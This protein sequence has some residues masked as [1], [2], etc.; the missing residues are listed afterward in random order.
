MLVPAVAGAAEWYEKIKLG[1]D[2]RFRNEL[3]QQQDKKDDFR[4]RIR[5]R[6]AVEAQVTESWSAAIG[7]ASG[8][9][10]PVSTNQTLT[11]GFSRKTIMLDLAYIDF[12]PT[13]VPGLNMIGGKMR[14]PFETADRTQLV[15]DN[16]LAPEGIAL[17]YKHAAGE[18]V[19]LFMN[20]AGFYIT[21]NDPDNEQWMSGG[22][23]GISMKPSDKMNM[24]AGGSY[25][26]YH[27]TKGQPG[28]YNPAKL[29]GNT[30]MKIGTAVVSGDT[31]DVF[32][33]ASDFNELEAFALFNVKINEKVS[34]RFMG[35]YVNNVAADSLNT[36][37]LFGGSL[38]YGKDKGSMKFWANYRTIEADA[39]IGAFTYSDSWGGGTNGKGLE[40]GVSYGLTKGASF[41]VTYLIDTKGIAEGD[42]GTDYDRL[43]VDF[44]AK[45]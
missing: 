23:A 20:G 19:E 41:D 35:D 8:S 5:A 37:Y 21:D 24:M 15:W 36:A 32:G 12:H 13:Q 40:L 14:L 39:L 26:D 22:Q 16:D 30:K 34:L 25:F 1:G 6:I 10:D 44:Q 11:S 2:V 33:Y 43:Q 29:Y 7:L 31:V 18:Q 9:L 45:F 4:W 3:I 42:A 38:A 17:R 28:I 27:R